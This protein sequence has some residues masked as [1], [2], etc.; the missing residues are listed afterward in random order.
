M[1]FV[2][3]QFL[4]ALLLLA[5][6]IAI[7]LFS[8]RR[9]K[10]VYFSSIR[11]LKE[12]QEQT[13][14]Q[15]KLKHLLLLLSRLFAL[16]FIILGFAQPYIPFSNNI[17]TNALEPFIFVDN[18]FSMSLQNEKGQ[19]LEQAKDIALGIAESQQIST[20]FRVGSHQFKGADLTYKNKDQAIEEIQEL[21]YSSTSHPLS[22]VFQR[23]KPIENRNQ[24]YY[25][26]SDFQT[27]ILTNQNIVLDSAE[28]VFAFLTR[29]EK[30]FNISLDSIAIESPYVRVNEPIQIRISFS[31]SNSEKATPA[32]IQVKVNQSVVEE[33][34]NTISAGSQK[35]TSISITINDTGWLAIEVS[36]DDQP[37]DY[38]NTLFGACYV[39]SSIE[40]LE[41]K[42]ENATNFPKLAYAQDSIF[43]LVSKTPKTVLAQDIEAFDLILLNEVEELSSGLTEV[44]RT[45]VNEGKNLAILPSSNTSLDLLSAI[46][47]Q[48]IALKKSNDTIKKAIHS[49][50][51][52]HAFFNNM[53]EGTPKLSFDEMN[54]S[55]FL[56]KGM[57]Q[58]ALINYKS[59]EAF[60]SQFELGAGKVFFFSS[61]ISEN[62]SMG[63]F[64]LFLPCLF[65]FGFQSGTSTTLAHWIGDPILM[66]Q[67][68]PNSE[69]PPQFIHSTTGKTFIPKVDYSD[70]KVALT[71]RS[72]ELEEG[73]YRLVHNEKEYALIGLNSSRNESNFQYLT[74][75]ELDNWFKSKGVEQF[76]ILPAT[77]TEIK[78]GLEQISQGKQ[79]WTY[80]LLLGLLFLAI[81][82]FLTRIL[83]T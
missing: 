8:L 79:L 9:Y 16:T 56:V 1:N 14:K 41:I 39:K 11:F 77:P 72:E 13:Q 43:H 3:P 49:I 21:N 58:E 31:N 62:K 32:S 68:L 59:G 4:W 37:Y 42:G 66:E 10:T 82:I 53:F 30:V 12:V 33:F 55:H 64:Q 24:V 45:R 57:P 60:L 52:N 5:I 19:L 75:L 81:E 70:N 54:L 7:H 83:K 51:T 2:Q 18:S 63:E 44:I 48:R 80:A 17:N 20:D 27:N 35:D 26:I 40:I 46:L 6:P 22:D 15:S 50:N 71:L 76:Q 78:T 25:L 73:F 61:S 28:T 74:E 36:V 47:P 67:K 23:F 29:P 34:T 69:S 65:E 38:D